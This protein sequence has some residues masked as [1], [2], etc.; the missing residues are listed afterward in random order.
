MELELTLITIVRPYNTGLYEPGE[1]TCTWD[2]L[3]LTRDRLMS[4]P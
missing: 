3:D 1:L 2:N 4:K